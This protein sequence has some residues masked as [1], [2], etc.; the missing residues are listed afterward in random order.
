MT[1]WFDEIQ[2]LTFDEKVGLWFLVHENGLSLSQGLEA[3]R[4]GITIYHGTKEDWV[5]RLIEQTGFFHGI[6]EQFHA[7]FDPAKL[8][9]DC[10]SEGSLREFNFAGETWCT[11]PLAY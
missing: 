6:S 3:I 11:N 1:V 8:V 9:R 7:N 4:D 10:E 2:H 5:G